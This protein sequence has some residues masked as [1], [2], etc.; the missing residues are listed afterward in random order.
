MA[1]PEPRTTH[2][3]RV[4]PLTWGQV[5]RKSHSSAFSSAAAMI[6]L[7][8]AVGYRKWAQS[9]SIGVRV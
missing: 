9:Y 3:R 4:V 1:L 5:S 8:L 2:D 7:T 6:A